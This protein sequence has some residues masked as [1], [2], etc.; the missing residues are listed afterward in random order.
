MYRVYS[1]RGRR[2]VYQLW[3][4]SSPTK[5]PCASCLSGLV[6]SQTIANVLVEEKSSPWWDSERLYLY[7]SSKTPCPCVYLC[8]PSV[9]WNT[10]ISRIVRMCLATP[11]E[12]VDEKPHLGRP[13]SPVDWLGVPTWGSI[14][15]VV[16]SV[17]SRSQ[18]QGFLQN[19]PLRTYT[20]C[21]IFHTR[22]PTPRPAR[23]TKSSPSPMTFLRTQGRVR[24][25]DVTPR[26]LWE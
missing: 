12:G 6:L 19:S 1:S 25:T 9:T 18:I 21:V 2:P 20:L 16:S 13:F 11:R 15:P 24:D 7:L 17:P 5:D 26:P 14:G 22:A 10:T 3:N 8:D 23:V 4:S